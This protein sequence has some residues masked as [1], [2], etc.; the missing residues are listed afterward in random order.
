MF[1][2]PG[3]RRGRSLGRPPRSSSFQIILDKNDFEVSRGRSRQ[4]ELGREDLEILHRRRIVVV[5][6][7]P[8]FSHWER[9][10]VGN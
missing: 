10:S 4:P 1:T 2:K 3:N 8:M 6:C 5:T 9:E 7:S